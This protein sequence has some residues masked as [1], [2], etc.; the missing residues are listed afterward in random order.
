[1]DWLSAAVGF[2]GAI[3]G[4]LVG[5]YVGGR[6]SRKASIEATERNV[7]LLK[8]WDTE[9]ETEQQGKEKRGIVL[10]FIGEGKTNLEMIEREGDHWIIPLAK[11]AWDGHTGNLVVYFDIED[12]ALL[13]DVYTQVERIN[14]LL[15]LSYTVDTHKSAVE[16]YKEGLK[17]PL[18]KLVAILEEKIE[19]G[20]L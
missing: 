10:D 9:R 3:I 5:A 11:R 1:M 20:L 12:Q 18:T 6:M 17:E 14:A 8:E 2:G 19:L 15:T 16:K 4:A 7:K 13:R